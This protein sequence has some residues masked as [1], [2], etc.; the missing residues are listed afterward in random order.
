MV[1]RRKRKS[2]VLNSAGNMLLCKTGRKYKTESI[3]RKDTENA[4]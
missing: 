1:L 2:K 3:E 4:F